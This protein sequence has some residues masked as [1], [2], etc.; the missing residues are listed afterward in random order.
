MRAPDCVVAADWSTDEKKRWM[1]RAERIDSG[2]YFVYPPEPVGDH[3]S[4]ITRLQSQLSSNES[5][6]IG[7]DF[8]IGLPLAYATQTGVGAFRDALANFGSEPWEKF[9]EISDSPSLRQP[10]FPRPTQQ[11]GQYK[12]QLARALGHASLSLLLRRC[13]LKT[14]SRK[15]AECLFFTLGGSQVGAGA[16]VGWRDVIQPALGQVRLWP[17]DGD[18][19]LLLAEPGVTVA[20]IYP[21][22]AY[23]HLGVKIGS[24]TG[25]TKTS[26]GDRRE[27][28][29][30]WVTEFGT[31]PIRL[32]AA[33]QSWVRWGFL[34]EDDFDAM[35]GLLSMLQV[36][37]GLRPGDAPRTDDV[38]MIEGWILGQ[39]CEG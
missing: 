19:S 37:C 18:L 38:R 1:V 3:H 2:A 31:G 23:S 14:T 36:V 16:I 34:A 27:V 12:S 5:L 11:K 17:F 35:A 6:L 20:E 10:F 13:D 21:A 29:R 24:G 4:L 30:H 33:A 32:S 15:A 26:R 7:F 22:E 25:R 8:P 28:S 39:R 9:Y